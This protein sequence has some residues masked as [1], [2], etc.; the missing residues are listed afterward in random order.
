[1]KILA[2]FYWDNNLTS[3]LWSAS[4]WFNPFNTKA[5]FCKL[6]AIAFRHFGAIGVKLLY[7]L[8]GIFLKCFSFLFGVIVAQA[9]VLPWMKQRYVQ[10]SKSPAKQVG[11]ASHALMHCLTLLNLPNSWVP[12]AMKKP[13][14][15]EITSDETNQNVINLK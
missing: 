7:S 14:C 3:V 13:L 5:H 2:I 12:P 15:V 11:V 6:N 10:G 1:M 9:V 4:L 8:H